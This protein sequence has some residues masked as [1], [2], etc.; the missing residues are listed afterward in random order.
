M[1]APRVRVLA[2]LLWAVVLASPVLAQQ[3]RIA[4]FAAQT[5]TSS[6]AVTVCQGVTACTADTVT[7]QAFV[8]IETNPIRWRADGTAPTT[9]TG[10]LANAGATISLAG[11]QNVVN[12]KMIATGSSATV[13]SS[14]SRP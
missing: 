8:S 6:A 7:N 1:R 10:H 9:T 2:W 3:A 4:Y 11:H 13:F 5:V 14:V 12:F